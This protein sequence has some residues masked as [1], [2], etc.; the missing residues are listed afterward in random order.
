MIIPESAANS[1]HDVQKVSLSALA[2]GTHRI[3]VSHA[4]GVEGPAL[5]FLLNLKM[6]TPLEKSV[7][8]W[9]TVGCRGV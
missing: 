2:W 6:C 8:D 7:P 1:F 5:F 3:L 9:V 4:V